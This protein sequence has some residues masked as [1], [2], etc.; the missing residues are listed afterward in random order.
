MRRVFVNEVPLF[1]ANEFGPND[2]FCLASILQGL[3]DAV[4]FLGVYKY[5]RDLFPNARFILY[6]DSVWR[7][8]LLNRLPACEKVVF[9]PL[10]SRFGL[11]DKLLDDEYHE[12]SG[13]ERS[14]LDIKQ[15]M[16]SG[17]VYLL[18]SLLIG[19]TPESFSLHESLIQTN[20]RL[21]GLPRSIHEI[22]PYI[23]VTPLDI[24]NA[25]NFIRSHGLTNGEFIVIAPQ[26]APERSWGGENFNALISYLSD[27]KKEKVVIAGLPSMEKVACKSAI[28]S[29]GIS[30]PTLAAI[31][32]KSKFFVGSDSGL[33]HLAACFDIPVIG[34]Y[35]KW[36][37]QFPFETRPHS[38]FSTIIV[39]REPGLAESKI[40]M[41][42]VTNFLDLVLR[43][44]SINNPRCP[45][46]DGSMDYLI[47][48]SFE[49]LNYLCVCGTQLVIGKDKNEDEKDTTLNGDDCKTLYIKDGLQYT[50][51]SFKSLRKTLK[52]QP[53]E[54]IIFKFECFPFLRFK[55]FSD[56]FG[57]SN[58]VL[59]SIE[60]LFYFFNNL[61]YFICNSKIYSHKDDKVIFEMV[62][63]KENHDKKFY[64]PWMEGKL[65]LNNSIFSRYFLWMS[66][67][68]DD[69][70]LEEL[71][72]RAKFWEQYKEAINLSKL[73]L[74]Y[75]KSP[76][77]ISR[78]FCLYLKKMTSLER[79]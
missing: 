24:E 57:R 17:P 59:P 69:V 13:V 11:N 28:N 7:E 54:R 21:I 5:V 46:C 40:L 66:W 70:F 22:R 34:I 62:F 41:E 79:S 67:V 19:R 64:I 16:E 72:R 32:S 36:N 39:E 33:T 1:N 42:T 68:S 45:L 77:I 37:K 48:A 6:A 14:L 61:G 47:D 15:R 63:F 74:P 43:V 20:Y 78:L 9:F 35:S 55:L 25:D 3:G 8:L 56:D 30:I 4:N 44:K 49:K 58:S 29:I 26:V 65:Y 53:V 38:P 31:I 60:G 71:I 76:R 10:S 18:S 51:N 23:P 50:A 52:R 2:S 75:L 12:M 27:V 73:I